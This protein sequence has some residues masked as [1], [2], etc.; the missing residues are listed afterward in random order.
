MN[1]SITGE[2][3]SGFLAT[4]KDGVSWQIS[5]EPMAY[6]KTVELDDGST[7]SMKKLERPQ[8]LIMNG[9][10]THVFFAC[11]NEK[12]EIFNMVRP[13]PGWSR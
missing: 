6:S 7:E 3:Q 11:R 2:A 13:L 8:V 1:D 4:S 10:P 9:R 5:A 12:D